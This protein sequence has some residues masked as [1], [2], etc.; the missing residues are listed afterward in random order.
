MSTELLVLDTNAYSSLKRGHDERIK[1]IVRS[2]S[3]IALP[4]IVV[5]ELIGGFHGGNRLDENIRLLERFLKQKSC[6]FL[7]VSRHTSDI[8][9]R[10]YDDLKR[11]GCLIPTNDIWIAALTIEYEGTLASYDQDFG[12]IKGLPLAL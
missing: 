2:S 9:G 7:E 12:A 10:L 6:A 3:G 11:R 5:G 4:S 1:H 8:Y